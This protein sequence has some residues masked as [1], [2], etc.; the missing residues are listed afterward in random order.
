MPQ[1]IKEPNIIPPNPPRW[2]PSTDPANIAVPGLDTSAPVNDQI[3]QIEQLITLK[4]QN[5][6]A[7]FSKMQ[8]IMSTRLLPAFKRYSV[9][10]EPVREAA[11][12]WTSFYE[13]AAQIRIP[14]SGDFSTEQDDPSSP[15]EHKSAQADSEPSTSHATDP[16]TSFDPNRTPSESS[17]MPGQGAVSSTPAATSRH[18]A[19]NPHD[20]FSTQG[21]PS[22]SASL[23]SPLVR[24][25]RDLRNFGQEDQSV[26]SSASHTFDDT[27]DDTIH[28]STLQHEPPAPSASPSKGKSRQHSLREDVLRSAHKA[29]SPLRFRAKP[30]TPI[31]LSRNPYLPEGSKPKDW[32]GIVDLRDPSLTTPPRSHRTFRTRPVTPQARPP[33]E[34]EDEDEDED[35]LPPG[36]SP[37]VMMQFATLPTLGRTPQKKA[38]ARIGQDL[39]GDARRGQRGPFG[40]HA[41]ESSMS[42]V[43]SPP[44][45]SRYTHNS[46]QASTTSAADSTL[47]SLLRRVNSLGHRQESSSASTGPSSAIPSSNP[48]YYT[49]AP[50]PSFARP[51][52]APPP[53]SLAPPPT[54][55]FATS[56][57]SL[58]PPPQPVTLPVTPDPPYYHY[59][60]DPTPHALLRDDDSLDFDDFDED[61]V[62]NT[63]H[64]SAA[65]L[66]ASRAR[67]ADSDSDASFGSSNT[68]SDSFGYDDAGGAP[69]HPFARGASVSDDFEDSFEDEGMEGG[70]EM[71]E[72]TV[73]GVPPAERAA[74][75]SEAG[76]GLGPDGRLRMLGADALLDTATLGLPTESPTPWPTGGRAV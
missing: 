35:L 16:S 70:G 33:D 75:A 41:V 29:V 26:A 65:F 10:T 17:F 45:I 69:V 58:A 22:W 74:R 14:T 56:S 43:S 60:E 39:L 76:L 59:P 3:D 66:L 1:E 53:S 28:A 52:P 51:L 48:S 7:N 50:G 20:T 55:S 68:S 63:A 64:P 49:S 38:A 15:S 5:I 67:G 72:E 18:R 62:N 2:E 34:D 32:S 73:F 19:Q 6:D 27:E 31:P 47:D 11:K 21:E 8:H 37:P 4:L 42:S 25:D 57:S 30:K 9:A 36:M 24:L 40:G 71:P 46:S 54:T 44:S 13:Q 61:E 12:F 23:E